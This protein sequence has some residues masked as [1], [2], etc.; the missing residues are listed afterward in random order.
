MVLGP[1]DPR[2]ATDARASLDATNAMR[3]LLGL[4]P[5]K[6]TPGELL[7]R[8]VAAGTVAGRLAAVALAEHDRRND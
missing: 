1:D 8:H 4:A 5:A 7:S 2:A 3:A 6:E